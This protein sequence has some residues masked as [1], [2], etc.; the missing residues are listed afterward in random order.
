MI[1]NI[2]RLFGCKEKS[3]GAG[4][5]EKESDPKPVEFL[6]KEEIEK[7]RSQ[8]VYRYQINKIIRLNLKIYEF[9]N[10]ECDYRVC[11]GNHYLN[12]RCGEKGSEKENMSRLYC[13]FCDSEF[14]Y[15]DVGKYGELWKVYIPDYAYFDR[16]KEG[17][18]IN[19]KDESKRLLFSTVLAYS[20]RG[21]LL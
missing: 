14:L 7:E 1:E 17:A 15:D 6:T 13:V 10:K 20:T 16:T 8:V 5:V 2:K 12:V 4:S 9:Q 3:C 21:K 11:G 19:F 18:F